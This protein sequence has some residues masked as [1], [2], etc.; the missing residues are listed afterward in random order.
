MRHL[1]TNTL[2]TISLC[3]LFRLL[4]SDKCLG[5]KR[6]DFFIPKGPPDKDHISEDLY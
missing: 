6:A 2:E 4:L 3:M 5:E 1:E